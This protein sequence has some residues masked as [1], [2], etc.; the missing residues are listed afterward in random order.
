MTGPGT[1][2]ARLEFVLGRADELRAEVYVRLVDGSA[3]A[4]IT[5]VLTGPRCGVATTL[6]STSALRPMSGAGT[7]VARAIVTEPAFWTPELPNLYELSA[8]ACDSAGVVATTRRLVGL[9]RLGVRGRSI[10][11]DG[12]RWVPRARAADEAAFDAFRL[13]HDSLAA[14]VG[15]P[16]AE[17]CTSADAAGVA[18]VAVPDEAIEQ[19]RLAQ[20]VEMWS[21]HPSV[22]LLILDPHRLETLATARI[23]TGT[24]LVGCAADAAEP[25]PAMLPRVADCIV[26]RLGAGALPHRGWIEQRPAVPIVAWRRQ[27]S[28]EGRRACDALQAE[29]AAWGC[30]G[31]AESSSDWA[32]YLVA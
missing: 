3:D 31:G 8:E 17:T 24:M 2:P 26:A 19:Q 32:G 29:L 27:A 25:P 4:T 20:R 22:V 30:A 21:Q 12:R 14:L 9:R 15:D 7:A 28:G 23:S 18:L 6:P 1:L 5:G 16:S 11:L 13:R 10:W